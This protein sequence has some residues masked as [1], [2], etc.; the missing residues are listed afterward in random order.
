[1][2]R[3]LYIAVC[4]GCGLSDLPGQSDDGPATILP[5]RWPLL[6]APCT[7]GVD[8]PDGLLVTTTDFSTGAVSVVDTTTRTVVSDVALGT[9]DGIPFFGDGRALVVH[10]FQYDFVDVLDP[11]RG[12]ASVGQHALS[13]EGT[14]APNPRGVALGSDGL[15]YVP[16]FDAPEIL[17][18]DLDRSPGQS[19]VDT[20]DV[21]PF[22]DTD[23]S[24]EATNPIACGDTMF[25]SIDRI[26]TDQGFA[27]AGG[28][29][30][31]AVDL[32]ERTALDLD[33]DEDGAQGIPVQGRW[34]KQLRIDPADPDR[35][36]LLALTEGIERIDLRDG[37]VS[38]AVPPDA[39]V[40]AG[41]AHYQLP[42]A[43]DV[44]GSMA[45]LVAYAAIEGEPDCAEDPAPCFEE[46]RLYRVGLDGE[47]PTV[48]EPFA[49]GIDAAERTLEVIGDELWFGSRKAGAPGLWVYDLTTDPPSVSDGPLGTGLPPFS[50]TAIELP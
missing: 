28:E 7:L 13:V 3:I 44:E 27:R 35:L 50:L 30:L 23:G 42:L 11:G 5:A 20:I 22:A 49:Y 39:F 8:A 43:F 31:I 29:G 33:P 6:T 36:T 18:L 24:P 9:P 12:F 21:S 19:I 48:P 26:A 47:A 16:L 4:A 10:R 32:A 41:I 17:V 15:A 2:R 38:W 45:W 46:A 37:T 40:A 14:G 34:I 1:M 25:V